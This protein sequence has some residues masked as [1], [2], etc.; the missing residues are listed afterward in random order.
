[1]MDDAEK[2]LG[3]TRALPGAHAAFESLFPDSSAMKRW[4]LETRFNPNRQVFISNFY[5]NL[6]VKVMT[7]GREIVIS[8]SSN[9]P[10]MLPLSIGIVIS[11]M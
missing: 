5:P 9:K 10:F 11:H 1:G 7:G 6:V 4:L 2:Y 3:A 8:S